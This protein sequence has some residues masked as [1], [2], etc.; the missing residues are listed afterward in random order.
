MALTQDIVATYRGPQRIFAR[1]LSQGRNEVRGLLFVLIAGILMFIAATPYQAREAALDPEIPL[2][3]RIYWSAFFAIF[4]VPIMV[5]LFAALIWVLARLGR[6][7]VT[8]YQIRFSLIWS[9][10]ASTPVLLLLGLTAGFVG[11]GVQVQLLS[12]VWLVVFVWFWISGLTTA[13]ETA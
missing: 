4:I 2:L 6:R 11:P 8:G 9:L 10:L 13:E 5:Y 1:F 7:R 3:A 12:L